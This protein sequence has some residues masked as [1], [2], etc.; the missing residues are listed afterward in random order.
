[1]KKFIKRV[2]ATCMIILIVI[3][4][5]PFCIFGKNSGDFLEDMMDPWADWANW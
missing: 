2:V 5:L 4:M 3:V 1:M